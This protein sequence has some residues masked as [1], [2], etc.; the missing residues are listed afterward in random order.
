M[1]GIL[2]LV[3]GT[4]GM[5]GGVISIIT[6]FSSTARSIRRSNANIKEVQSFKGT[7]D[8]LLAAKERA[9]K[10]E[11][12]MSMKI[13]ALEENVTMLL[14]KNGFSESLIKKYKLIVS[15]L[16]SCKH[17]KLNTNN[18]PV[19]IKLRELEIEK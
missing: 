14:D 4:V 10:S 17:N 19:A 5:I 3:F 9:E 18:C 13:Q 8:L 11:K 16:D 6:Y 2:T 7:I 12:A 15:Y 1:G